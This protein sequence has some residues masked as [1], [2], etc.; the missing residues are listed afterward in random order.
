MSAPLSK[1]L[2]RDINR[3]EKA[4][5]EYDESSSSIYFNNLS[6]SSSSSTNRTEWVITSQDVLDSPAKERSPTLKLKASQS[7]QLYLGY[8]PNQSAYIITNQG[9]TSNGNLTL[10]KIG[11]KS[12][13]TLD[14]SQTILGNSDVITRFDGSASFTQPVTFLD[15]AIYNQG[16]EIT[17]GKLL[18]GEDGLSS[19]G[20]ITTDAAFTVDQGAPSTFTGPVSLQSGLKL[21]S[22]ITLQPSTSDDTQSKVI[23]LPPSNPQIDNAIVYAQ[24]NQNVSQLNYTKFSKDDLFLKSTY[25]PAS[26]AVLY[27]DIVTQFSQQ[28]TS[29]SIPLSPLFGSTRRVYIWY[30]DLLGQL[31]RSIYMLRITSLS[32]SSVDFSL[33]TG[34]PIGFCPSLV[35][36]SPPYKLQYQWNAS[37]FQAVAATP[38]M[39]VVSWYDRSVATTSLIPF[40]QSNTV[41]QLYQLDATNGNGFTTFFTNA[42]FQVI[43]VDSRSKS[44]TYT[45]RFQRADEPGSVYVYNELTNALTSMPLYQ[46]EQTNQGLFIL[47]DQGDTTFRL[48]STFESTTSVQVV[49]VPFIGTFSN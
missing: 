26:N 22:T 12:N 44:D 5:I 41:C 29:S 21:G 8:D 25:A 39:A 14:E 38:G 30:I 4:S 45:I 28:P 9:Q 47:M 3:I 35:S 33:E 40:L 18:V 23:Q 15:S 10:L 19:Q 36:T 17:S 31:K 32:S 42:L 2:F 20:P 34:Q 1:V 37:V 49:F 13:I 6:P 46:A 48:K 11:P 7:H 24:K 43:L 27:S 16:L